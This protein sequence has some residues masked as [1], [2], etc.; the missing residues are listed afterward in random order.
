MT[1]L[2]FEPVEYRL[3]PPVVTAR[4]RV[5]S[6][7]GY[8]V[9]LHDGDYSASGEVLPLSGWTTTTIEEVGRQLEGLA[10]ATDP[11]SAAIGA[12]AEV[13][14]GVDAAAWMLRA[15]R[16]GRPLWRELGGQSSSVSVNALV[17]GPDPDGLR[18]SIEDALR[19]GYRSIKAKV[20]FVDDSQRL[21]AI[22]DGL[23]D[24]VRVR[25]DPNGSWTPSEAFFRAGEAAALLGDRLEYVEDPVGD[26]GQLAE[27]RSSFPVPIAVDDLITAPRSRQRVLAESLADVLVVKPALVGGVTG[28]LGIKREA[29]RAGLTLVVSSTY[30][31]PAGLEA[32]CHLAAAI[33]PE[34]AHGLGTAARVAHPGMARLVPSAGRITLAG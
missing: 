2:S 29:D 7:T 31:G 32:W 10:A 30:D 26:I 24:D 17:D 3:E 25:L 33:A 4:G 9:T 22:A 16:S 19:A 1:N 13:R 11:V 8:V 34:T 28:V 21:E 20:G 14:S 5:V 27:I 15:A 12:P 18:S 23:P 6:R